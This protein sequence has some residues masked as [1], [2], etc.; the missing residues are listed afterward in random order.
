MHSKILKERVEFI[1]ICV[2]VG[3]LIF[4]LSFYVLG[5]ALST[6]NEQA[7]NLIRTKV[8]T[9]L[10]QRTNM[11]EETQMYQDFINKGDAEMKFFDQNLEENYETAVVARVKAKNAYQFYSMGILMKENDVQKKMQITHEYFLKW[12]R[13]YCQKKLERGI[14]AYSEFNNNLSNAVKKINR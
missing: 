2:G 4:S 14:S 12:D 13:V 6:Y 8:F 10:Y 1:L 7:R 11:V 3:V 5:S 9:A